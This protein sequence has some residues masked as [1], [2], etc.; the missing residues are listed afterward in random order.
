[1]ACLQSGGAVSK[2]PSKPTIVSVGHD[3]NA[4]LISLDLED[5][6]DCVVVFELCNVPEMWF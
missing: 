4:W 3:L 5:D 2:E 6:L 1:M